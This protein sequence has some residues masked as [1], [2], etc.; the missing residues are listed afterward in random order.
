MVASGRGVVLARLHL[1]FLDGVRIG[2]SRSAAEVPGA[3]R[4]D[5]SVIGEGTAGEG[6]GAVYHPKTDESISYHFDPM[7]IPYL[8][9]WICQGGWP[10]AGGGQFTA[11]LEPCTG[12]SDS[13]TQAIANGGCATLRPHEKKKWALRIRVQSGLPQDVTPRTSK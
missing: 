2:R 11:A 10:V 9:I 1:E 8:G 13:L 5:L 4:V 7:L 12:S 3:F 6:S